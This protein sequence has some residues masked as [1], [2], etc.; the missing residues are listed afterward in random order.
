[1]DT[2]ILRDSAPKGSVKSRAERAL[3]LFEERGSLVRSVAA[4]TFEVPS[5]G[6]IGK[7][8]VVRYGGGLESCTCKD[9]EFN[10][11][12]CKH[13]ICV[14]IAHAAR[15]SGIREIRILATV[16]GDPFKAAS[17]RKGCP[18]CFGGYVTI[19]VE[20]DGQEHEEAVS[21]GRCGS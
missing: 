14:G 12:S 2:T 6:M 3:A 20:E 8:Y 18:A 9:F 5:C 19:T 1:M 15:R 7:R 11:G 17:R 16:A 4:D 10:G 13:L 21:C